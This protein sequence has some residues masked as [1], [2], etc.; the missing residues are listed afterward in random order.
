MSRYSDEYLEHWGEVFTARDF[1]RRT[2]VPFH[3]FLKD[4]EAYID[5]L[6]SDP[7]AKPLLS[8]Q[9]ATL[10]RVGLDDIEAD[11][12][13]EAL[14]PADAEVHGERTVEVLRHRSRKH[15][16]MPRHVRHTTNK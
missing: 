6:D 3:I 11:A 10:A 16:P 5:M 15:N 1:Y 2:G 7:D 12:V 8:K 14:L 13:T 4:P 9:Q